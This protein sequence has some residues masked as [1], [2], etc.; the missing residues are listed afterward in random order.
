MLSP[1]SAADN[2]SSDIFLLRFASSKSIGLFLVS[3]GASKAI[4][5]IDAVTKVLYNR[6]SYTSIAASPNIRI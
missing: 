3:T 5:G 4:I 6:A 2:N 1:N